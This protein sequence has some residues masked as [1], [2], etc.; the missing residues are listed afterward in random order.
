MKKQHETLIYSAAGLAALF[1]ILVAANHLVSAARVRADLT[2][3]RLYTLSEGT[4]EILRG[5]DSPVK[6]RL[7]VAPG[8]SMPVPLRAFAGR[9]ADMVKEF[10]AVAGPNLVVE[11]YRP[12]P[13]SGRGGCRAARRHRA[14]TARHR[15]RVLPRRRGEP[16]RSPAGDPG[17]LAAARAAARVRPRAGGGARRRRRAYQGRTD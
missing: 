11:T 12:R 9:V 16:A 7:Y 6:L 4:R 2:E 13:D 14:A 3:G 15:R 10:E 8:D 5:L 17:D 1:V